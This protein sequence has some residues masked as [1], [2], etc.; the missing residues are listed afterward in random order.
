[1]NK[2]CAIVK[3]NSLIEIAKTLVLKPSE[4]QEFK[5]WHRD[6]EVAIEKIFGEGTKH[7]KDF[8]DIGYSLIAF[9]T[10]TSD[11]AFEEAYQSGVKTAIA[12]LKSFID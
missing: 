6:T 7:S 2:Q 9:S 3:L 10:S 1:L 11:Y 12:V 4:N 5:K 8:E